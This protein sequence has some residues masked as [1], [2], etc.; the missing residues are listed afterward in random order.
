[1]KNQVVCLPS[2]YRHALKTPATSYAVG[3]EMLSGTALC[4][5]A[6]R[7]SGSIALFLADPET[8]SLG[9]SKACKA[10][11]PVRVLSNKNYTKLFYRDNKHGKRVQSIDAT[12]L[13]GSLSVCPLA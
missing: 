1:M 2:L 13:S 11:G 10:Y 12:R 8:R 3:W 4:A 6:S 5:E 9:G 7:G